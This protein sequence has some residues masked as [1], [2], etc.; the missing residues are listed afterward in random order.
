MPKLPDL[1]VRAW[2]TRRAW[3]LAIGTVAVAGLGIIANMMGILGWFGITP[4]PPGAKPIVPIASEPIVPVSLPGPTPIVP[5]SLP[6]PTPFPVSALDEVRRDDFSKPTGWDNYSTQDATTGYEAGKYFIQMSDYFL[7]L[8]IWKDAGIVDNAVLQVDV[9]NQ[10]NADDHQQGIG[11]GWR[12]GWEGSTYAFMVDALG[13]C[14]FKEANKGWYTRKS[15][16]AVNYDKEKSYHTLRVYIRYD[17]AIGFVDGEFCAKYTMA[18]YVPGYVGV[19]AAPDTSS[20][21]GKYYFDE[22]RIFRTP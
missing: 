14:M 21:R 11:Y 7:F 10:P 4:V 15:E 19:A 5:V 18:N 3:L 13:N 9:L 16:H 8:S 6:G 20:K 1:I 12:H 17:E 22:F 2:H